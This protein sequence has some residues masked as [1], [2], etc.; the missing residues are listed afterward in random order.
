[1]CGFAGEVR[2]DGGAA[3]VVAV[4]R[5]TERLK[6]RGPDGTGILAHDRVALGHRRLK[7]IDLSDASSQ[8]MLDP[9]LGLAIVFNGCIYNYKELRA[10]LEAKG[11]CFFSEGDT[12]VI[13]KA[14]H[15]FGLDFVSRL[16]GMFAFAIHERESGRL[17]L[18][19]DRFGIKPLYYASTGRRLRFASSLPALLAGGEVD[20]AIDRIALDNYITLNSV[21]PA[22]R[23]IL[24]GVGKLPPATVRVVEPNGRTTDRHYWSTSYEPDPA[25]PEAS[26]EEWR[27]RLLDALRLAVK[28]RMVADV[29]VGVLL[30]GGVD[31]SL[32][33]GLLAEFGQTGLMTFSIGFED[34][35][36]EKGDE[37]AYSDLVAERFHTDHRRIFIDSRRLFEALPA[38]IAAMS[39]PMISHDYVGF[40][41]LGE[42]VAKHIKVVQTGQGAD[43]VFAGYY[44]HRLLAN[45]KDIVADHARVYF[46]PG[47]ERVKQH[48]CE[49]S[50]AGDGASQK[51]IADELTRPGAATPTDRVLRLDT[52]VLLAENQLKRVDDMTMAWGIEARVPFVDH[53]LVEL[54]ARIPVNYKLI[55]RGK[56]ILKDVARTLIPHE[57]IDRKKGYF[58]V[59]TLQRLKEPYAEMVRDTLASAAARQRG[60]FRPS[61]LDSLSAAPETEPSPLASAEL[62]QV[63]LLEMWLQANGI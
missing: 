13:L 42:E 6:L 12:E 57:V 34:A 2:F 3:D 54:A 61:Y 25:A 7:V 4:A 20:T 31:S 52:T 46:S 19:R 16:N 24:A 27:D 10:E 18:A 59:P 41:L 48:L 47:R 11:Y 26:R 37:F 39:E 63:G 22:P 30:S 58:P 62:W 9:G 49:A 8:P 28:R 23:T 33:V 32:V 55:N 21:V 45:S 29:P 60:L 51:L 44:R 1:M 17:I 38:T 36:D 50:H 40:Y 56:A 14:Y 43:E 5:M 53:E 15:A 35:D